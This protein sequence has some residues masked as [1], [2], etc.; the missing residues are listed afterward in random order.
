MTWFD[1]VVVTFAQEIPGTGKK[2]L[3]LTYMSFTP[4]NPLRVPSAPRPSRALLG[5][6][7]IAVRKVGVQSCM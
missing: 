5:H 1:T 4:I 7:R 2:T 6:S 3:Q